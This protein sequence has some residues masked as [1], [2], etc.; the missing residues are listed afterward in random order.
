MRILGW[1]LLVLGILA[2]VASLLAGH[3]LAGILWVVLGAYFIH[4]ANQKDQEKE[5]KDKWER[6]E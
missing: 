2:T 5:D 3:G 1:I 6:G 4:R